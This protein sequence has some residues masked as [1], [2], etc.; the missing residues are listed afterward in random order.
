MSQTNNVFRPKSFTYGLG[1]TT[2][3]AV[4]KEQVKPTEVNYFAFDLQVKQL[5]DKLLRPVIDA[6]V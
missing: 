6:Q 1:E 5:I 2:K 3:N 4:Q